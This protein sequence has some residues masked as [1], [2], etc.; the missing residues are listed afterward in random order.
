MNQADLLM[1][2][3]FCDESF[4]EFVNILLT[5]GF[6]IS[7]AVDWSPHWLAHEVAFCTHK[8]LK[9][10]NN[11]LESNFTVEDKD[12]DVIQIINLSKKCKYIKMN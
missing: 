3:R 1:I 6:I 2:L 5:T 4:L 11:P 7:W 12:Y 9:I 10:Y 8:V